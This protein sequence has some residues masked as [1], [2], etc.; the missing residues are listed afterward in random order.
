MPDGHRVKNA[1]APARR[2]AHRHR[3]A[4]LTLGVDALSDLAHQIEE[5]FA[6]GS[7]DWERLRSLANDL[8]ELLSQVRR[9][10]TVGIAALKEL[11]HARAGSLE[12]SLSVPALARPSILDRHVPATD[13]ASGAGIM[14]ARHGRRS[15]EGSPVIECLDGASRRRLVRERQPWKN[16]TYVPKVEEV[17]M[18][19]SGGCYRS[20]KAVGT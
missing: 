12:R 4:S 16:R 15:H 2:H 17:S 19:K 9:S 8:D 7:G 1:L 5:R 11:T 3:S 18:A 13:P 14:G 6:K 10:T 20:A